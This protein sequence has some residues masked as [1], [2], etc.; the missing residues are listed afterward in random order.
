MGHSV[1][2]RAAYRR[3]LEG[4]LADFAELRYESERVLIDGDRAAVPYRMSFRL[5]S[6][7]GR[8]VTIRGVFMLQVDDDGAIMRRTD[9]WDSADVQQQLG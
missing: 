5:M 7:G 6:A 8:P 2:G 3:R 9:Y 1:T 4:F